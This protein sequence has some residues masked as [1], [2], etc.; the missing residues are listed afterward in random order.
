MCHLPDSFYIREFQGN[1]CLARNMNCREQSHREP[2]WLTGPLEQ[3]EC[4]MVRGREWI[5][6]PHPGM[7][8]YIESMIAWPNSEQLNKVAPSIC[9]SKS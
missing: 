9:R 2:M 7:Q 3:R 6:P 4:L 5:A 1:M 8:V